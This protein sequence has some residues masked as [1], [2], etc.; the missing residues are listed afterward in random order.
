M[1]YLVVSI[2]ANTNMHLSDF[3]ETDRNTVYHIYLVTHQGHLLIQQTVQ[4]QAQLDTELSRR[5][6]PI[7]PTTETTNS[8]TAK[9]T[10]KLAQ[11]IIVKN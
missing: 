3:T 6:A 1:I 2:R 8:H 11:Q 10:I 9:L 4:Q 7:L 5:E